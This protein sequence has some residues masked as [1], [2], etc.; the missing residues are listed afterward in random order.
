MAVTTIETKL[1]NKKHITGTVYEYTFEVPEEFEFTPGQFV[2]VEVGNMQRRSYSILS[3]QANELMLLVDLSPG[4]PGSQFFDT[5]V[6]SEVAKLMGPFGTFA[7]LDSEIEKVFVATGT[8]LVPFVPMIKDLVKNKPQVK[9]S[10]YFGTRYLEE[11]VA[12]YYLD[13]E[14]RDLDNFQIIR[15]ISRD[16][17]EE[18][19]D[20]MIGRVT[21]VIPNVIQDFNNKEFY[22]CGVNE[23]IEDMEQVLANAGVAKDMIV[24]EKYG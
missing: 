22:L 20:C 8:G 23:M 24:Y 5:I 9:I 15:C 2:S 16:T 10:L 17:L 19:N 14:I 4:G 7:C 12:Y 3:K 18:T 1:R 13:N 6:E 21:N 11:N